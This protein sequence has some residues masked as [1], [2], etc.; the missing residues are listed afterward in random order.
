MGNIPKLYVFLRSLYGNMYVITAS[1]F[2]ATHGGTKAPP[3]KILT[4]VCL[5]EIHSKNDRNPSTP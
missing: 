3:Y 4:T 5:Q 1:A 2:P